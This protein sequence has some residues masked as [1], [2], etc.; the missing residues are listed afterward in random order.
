MARISSILLS[1]AAASLLGGCSWMSSS[2]PAKPGP[3][4]GSGSA[5]GGGGAAQAATNPFAPASIRIHPLTR[6]VGG[7]DSPLEVVIHL[8]MRDAW[9]DST[10][11][12]G[13]LMLRIV[14]QRPSSVGTDSMLA[15]AADGSTRW[16][17]DLSD[18]RT[19]ASMFDPATRT[20]RMQLTGVP[21]WVGG[22]EGADV[23]RGRT[24][25]QATLTQ[26]DNAP[27][28]SAEAILER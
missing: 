18:L 12:L 11:G 16:D 8:E 27:V 22:S 9:G 26:P 2:D 5:G 4:R 10:K 1:M 17:I 14:R 3:I 25:I 13:S 23:V 19:N 20:Y 7:K 6:T 21:A 28:L 24:L 15:P